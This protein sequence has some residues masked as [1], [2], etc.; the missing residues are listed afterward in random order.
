[1]I[2]LHWGQSPALPHEN[3]ER[4]ALITRSD[5]VRSLGRKFGYGVG[6]V[7]DYIVFEVPDILSAQG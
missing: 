3:L 2:G 7:T 1:M 4:F 5:H 6:D